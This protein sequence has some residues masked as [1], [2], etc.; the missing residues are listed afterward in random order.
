MSLI[1]GFIVGFV[2]ASYL[3]Y[4]KFSFAIKAYELVEKQIKNILNKKNKKNDE[5]KENL[6][7]VLESETKGENLESK[8]KET[9]TE[10]KE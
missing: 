4:N 3:F 1:L 5:N 9:K 10:T 6:K 8:A 2:L 7:E